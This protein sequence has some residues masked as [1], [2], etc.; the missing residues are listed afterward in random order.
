MRAA[1]TLGLILLVEPAATGFD[2]LIPLVALGLIVILVMLV[3][4]ESLTRRR[5]C[6]NRKPD[7]LSNNV[8]QTVRSVVELA[9][10]TG[11]SQDA[12]RQMTRRTSSSG[13]TTI[14]GKACRIDGRPTERAALDVSRRRSLNRYTAT[15]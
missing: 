6:G 10:D 5:S 13:R 11:L 1:M 12:V 8:S 14:S 2:G 7:I 4:V 9:R 3:A 15:A